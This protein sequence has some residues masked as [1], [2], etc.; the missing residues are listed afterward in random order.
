[1]KP[2]VSIITMM[3]RS[4]NQ[5]FDTVQS[6]LEQNYEKIEIIIAD[7]YSED[8][9]KEEIENYIEKNKSNNI[10]SYTVYQNRS[11]YGTVKN[12]NSA[13]KN[14]QGDIL[15]NLSS[16]DLFFSCD[17]I[18]RIV[19]EFLNKGCN[20]LCTR[21]A[22]FIEYK[23]VIE[24]MIPDEFEI[25]RIKKFNSPD[26]QYKA[27][28]SGMMFNMASGCALSYKKEF[29]KNIGY[30]DENYILWEDGPFFA[31]YIDKYGMLDYNYDIISI[32]YRY[33]GVSTAGMPELMKRDA[34]LFLNDGLKNSS[35]DW[36]TKR[37]IKYR[38]NQISN[39]STPIFT[40]VKNLFKYPDVY[41][42][43]GIGR[44]Q[45][46]LFKFYKYQFKI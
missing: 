14:A 39:N 1:M 20:I 10:I 29:I 41:L 12:I 15:I 35:L 34:L 43:R 42:I 25:S 22:Y 40:M 36:F 11:N 27:F 19:E 38:I 23:D 31:R 5:V 6:I 8:F 16:G 3:Y 17:T 45:R 30:F 7:D 4:M 33:G 2:L 9:I 28:Y 21:R 26:Q 13:I 37:N 18:S 44:A 24:K 32:F 46:F